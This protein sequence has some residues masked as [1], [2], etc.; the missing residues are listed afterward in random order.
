M[1]HGKLKADTLEHSTAGSID[2]Q[3]VVNGS[4]KAW[5]SYNGSGTAFADSFNM[6]SATDNS[7]GNYTFALTNAM[8]NANYAASSIIHPSTS[9]SASMQ[10]CE[11]DCSNGYLAGSLRVE[12][13]YTTSNPSYPRVE[14]DPVKCAV[15][16]HGDLA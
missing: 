12:N 4:A 9:T 2:T 16:I 14:F 13:A 6:A 15:A 7:T 10:T 11:A 3:F 1:A 5:C 8:G